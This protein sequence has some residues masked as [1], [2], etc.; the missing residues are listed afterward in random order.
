MQV[1]IPRS[2]SFLL[3]AHRVTYQG[4]APCPAQRKRQECLLRVCRVNTPPS[5]RSGPALAA[6]AADSSRSRSGDKR[7]R[8]AGRLD[9]GEQ[10][11]NSGS[12]LGSASERRHELASSAG[13]AAGWLP[14]WGRAV[15]LQV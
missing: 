13:D 3:Q 12:D 7:T 4:G 5:P 15:F 10:R 9:G 6:P 11:R 14:R 8:W 1:H 2:S